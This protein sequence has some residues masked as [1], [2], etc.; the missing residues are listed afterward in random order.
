MLAIYIHAKCN[1]MEWL[2]IDASSV[3]HSYAH[4]T[5]QNAHDVIYFDN[6]EEPN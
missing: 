5:V 1:K 3:N 2:V 4:I 6:K